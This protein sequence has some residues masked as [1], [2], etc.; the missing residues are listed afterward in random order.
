MCFLGHVAG[1]VR[2]VVCMQEAIKKDNVDTLESLLDCLKLLLQQS[3]LPSKQDITVEKC[4]IR[5]V[6]DATRGHCFFW[7]CRWDYPSS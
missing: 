6:K 3:Y 4:I 5:Q 1:C 2:L 7:I